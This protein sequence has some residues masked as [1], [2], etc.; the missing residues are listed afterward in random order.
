MTAYMH[1]FTLFMLSFIYISDV[2]F[3]QMN[4]STSTPL[5]I[6]QTAAELGIL[7]TIQLG[8]VPQCVPVVWTPL[9]FAHADGAALPV[10]S[11]AVAAVLVAGE[12]GTFDAAAHLTAVLVPP[13]GRPTHALCH[14]GVRKYSTEVGVNGSTGDSVTTGL[15]EVL[16]MSKQCTLFSVAA[17]N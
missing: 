2:V 15:N 8:I 14:G 7:T 12:G 3:S 1:N 17:L 13:A 10:L 9:T 11:V 16:W 4:P 5:A 6:L